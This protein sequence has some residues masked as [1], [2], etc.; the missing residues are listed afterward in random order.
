MRGNGSPKFPRQVS[1]KIGS[2]VY[3]ALGKYGLGTPSQT[4]QSPKST[5]SVP[6]EH[7]R[8]EP[9]NQPL[10]HSIGKFPWIR[11]LMT[12]NPR[13]DLMDDGVWHHCET[14]CS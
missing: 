12:V 14:N 2:I 8:I 4:D 7:S 3:S 11:S 6:V 5:S 10:S 13:W 9:L 1:T